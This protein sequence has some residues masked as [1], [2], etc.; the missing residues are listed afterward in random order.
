MMEFFKVSAVRHPTS[1]CPVDGVWDDH[2]FL[3]DTLHACAHMGNSSAW[4]M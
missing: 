2:M 4:V 3:L 1:I